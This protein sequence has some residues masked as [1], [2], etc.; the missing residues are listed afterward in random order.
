MDYRARRILAT[1]LNNRKDKFKFNYDLSPEEVF[2]VWK[3]KTI[4]NYKYVLISTATAMSHCIFELTF[5]GDKNEWYI[6]H[7][8][9][10]NKVVVNN[11]IPLSEQEI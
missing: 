11:T 8:Q 6:D 1:Y 7:Y 9:K 3:C 5:N 10:V 4:Q 2:V